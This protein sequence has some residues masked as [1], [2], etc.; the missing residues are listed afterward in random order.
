M[1]PAEKLMMV[2][3]FSPYRL[4]NIVGA[5]S[6]EGAAS[7]SS[8][9]KDG[10]N[11]LMLLAD[12]SGRSGVNGFRHE[13][14]PNGN[15][16]SI[17]DNASFSGPSA[18]DIDCELKADSYTG[19]QVWLSHWNS[20]AVNQRS[21]ALGTD[22]GSKMRLLL[23]KDGAAFTSVLSTANI[24]FPVTTYGQARV[25][26]DGAT[27]NVTFYTRTSFNSNWTQLGDVVASGVTGS[28]FDSNTDFIIGGIALGTG[29]LYGGFIYSCNVRV[30]I[31]GT[32]VISINFTRAAKLA[33]SFVCDTGQT[34]TITTTS[35][36]LPCRIIGDRDATMGVQAN[37]PVVS[38][39]GGQNIAT[40]DG[41]NDYIRTA[42]FF[43]SVSQPFTRITV[44][45]QVSWT[46]NDV[47]WGSGSTTGARLIQTGVTPNV[48]MT[49]AAGGPQLATFVLGAVT[50]FVEIW[51]G[52]SS[53]M[54]RNQDTQT[55][56]S[57]PGGAGAG[58]FTLGANSDGSGAANIGLLEQ[59][60]YTGVMPRGTIQQIVQFYTRKYP[61]LVTMP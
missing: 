52:A 13:T 41:S 14:S 39:V 33:T 37:Q 49:A 31:G 11:R 20:N 16:A 58:G 34:V 19:T 7:D 9:L 2:A 22:G 35:T 40:F 24:A 3:Q 46:A 56:A 27:G 32:P 5:Y 30:A 26:W 28:L 57:T 36:A 1:T 48:Q 10:S 51:N 45:R 17:P 42:G 43:P 6:T 59:I 44:A 23:S 18:L 25:T 50:V 29:N 47:L 21:Y 38:S 53:T 15:Y 54:Q 8:H 60:I 55:A 4:P 12:R 61:G